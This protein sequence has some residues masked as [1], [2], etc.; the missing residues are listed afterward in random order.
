MEGFT[1]CYWF[2]DPYVIHQLNDIKQ[3]LSN[4]GQII[5]ANAEINLGHSVYDTINS[6]LAY[7]DILKHHKPLLERI[8]NLIA[9]WLTPGLPSVD[10]PT[11]KHLDLV[12]FQ[13]VWYEGLRTPNPF[14]EGCRDTSTEY[15]ID[16]EFKVLSIINRCKRDQGLTEFTA[17][18]FAKDDS[19]ARWL[20]FPFSSFH[21]YL[22]DT[23]YQVVVIGSG[24]MEYLWVLF[25][26]PEGH[27]NLDWVE[28]IKKALH[29]KGVPQQHIAALQHRG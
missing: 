9:R 28:S 23:N 14:Q 16:P 21:I 22:I 20:I 15:C 18:A 2:T 10:I 6:F 11:V 3:R 25:R 19:Y 29:S 8:K 24:G 4:L 7:Q 17:T 1:L 27:L 26:D 13:G 5:K 12:K